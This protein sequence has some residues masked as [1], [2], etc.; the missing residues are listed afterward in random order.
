MKPNGYLLVLLFTLL[1]TRLVGQQLLKGV[2]SD[3]HGISIPYAKLYVKNAAENRTIADANGYYEMRLFQGEYFLVITAEGFDNSEAYVTINDVTVQKNYQLFPTKFMDL[4]D[5][6]ASAKK[7]NPGRDIMLKVVQR[8][9][10]INPWNFP[11][12]VQGYTKAT[13][14][15]ERFESNG[16]KRKREKKENEELE[17]KDPSGIEDPFAEQRKED[18]EFASNMNLIEIDFTRHYGGRF[19]VKEIRNAYEERAAKR[20]NLYYT[21]TVKSNFNFFENLLHLDDL[22]QTPVS[23][24]ISVPGILSYKYRLEDQYEENGVKIHKIKIIPRTISTTTLEGYIY[25]ID[26][27]WLVQK[28]DFTMEK[29]NLLIYDYFSIHQ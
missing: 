25:V 23:S 9:D 29:G 12:T 6:E 7:S 26:S 18:E 27:L 2:I 3:E 10:T 4:E 8:R 22:H 1:G 28:L 5:V 11:H 13:E 21:T 19:D 15:I 16:D 17:N 14:N 24:P 20:T